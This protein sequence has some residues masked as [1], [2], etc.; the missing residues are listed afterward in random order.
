MEKSQRR[1]FLKKS[2][3]GISGAA[4]FPGTLKADQ[5]AVDLQSD[6]PQLPVRNLGQTGIKTPLLSLGAGNAND[7][8]FVKAAYHAG[9]K[10]FFSATYYGEGKNEKLVG[11]A[12]KGLPRHSFVVGT[13]VT[14]DGLDTRNG[15][16]TSPFDVNGYI[17]KAEESLKRFGLGQLDFLLFPYAEKREVVLN[18]S[19]M[20]ALSEFKKQGKTKFV[21]IAT[22]SNCPEAIRAAA[23]SGFYNIVMTAYN[24]KADKKQELNDAIEYSVNKGVGVVAMKT[25]A[26]VY[27]EKNTSNGPARSRSAIATCTPRCRRPNAARDLLI[28]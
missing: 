13:A 27:E 23:D 11:D 7:P 16:F 8:N 12:L 5:S 21:G 22:H 15:E 4:L 25:L 1:E 20:K 14:P 3:F 26:G 9:L 6:V 2:F 10:L 19:L 28:S 24:F 18:N 17:K